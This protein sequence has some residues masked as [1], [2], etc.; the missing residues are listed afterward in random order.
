[1]A[2]GCA[3]AET[4]SSLVTDSLLSKQ[5]YDSFRIFLEESCGIV[6]G[7]NKH[8]LVT[9]RLNRLTQEFSFDSLSAMIDALKHRNDKRLKER[10]VD[11]MTTNETSWFRDTYPYELLRENLVPELLK[12]KPSRLRIWSAASST[13]QEPYSISMILSETKMKSPGFLSAPVEIVGTDISNTVLEIARRGEYD[14]LS[15]ARG[16]SD[17]RRKIF[18]KALDKDRWQLQDKIKS[19]VKFSELNLLQNYALLG[20]FDLIF[21]RNVL[22]Y[23]SAE[24]KSDI[25]TRMAK[26]LNPG[27]YII[28][29]GS[30]SPTGYCRDFEMV[31]FSRGVVYR[32]KN[33]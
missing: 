32:L 9:S 33:K 5:Q 8:Y 15:L 18:F 29:G 23:F 10:V 4:D 6:L 3:H 30:E 13:G 14:G 17:E 28:L 12:K 24:L 25:L 11:A 31:R 27:G 2:N 1:M 22:I 20:K 21:C 26:A 19:I 16:I 7:D